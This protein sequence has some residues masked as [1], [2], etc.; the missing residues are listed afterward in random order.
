MP[1]ISQD[2]TQERHTFLLE[3]FRSQADLTRQDAMDAYKE[4]FGATIN[5]KTLNQLREQALAEAE[6]SDGAAEADEPEHEEEPE[7]AESASANLRA[8]AEAG[9]AQPA[10]KPAKPAKGARQKNVFVDAPKEHL[11][12]LQRIVGQLQEAG[13]ANVRIDHA[14]DRWMVLVVDG[15]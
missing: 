11:D 1:R 2:Q 4:K 13:A 15:K 5:L 14:T 7:A 12:F 3:L 6:G 10:Q 8:A 9:T